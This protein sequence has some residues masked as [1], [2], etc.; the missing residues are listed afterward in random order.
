MTVPTFL[1]IGVQ[2]SGT[3]TLHYSLAR[4]PQIFMSRIKETN[5][6]L[7]DPHGVLPHW[8][9]AERS[10]PRTWEEYTELFAGAG[11]Q[12]RAIGESSPSYLYGPV[13]GRIKAR[14]P[15]VKLIVILRHPVDQARSILATWLGRTPSLVELGA[16]LDSAEPGPRGELPLALHGRFGEH[17]EPYYERFRDILVLRFAA[18]QRAP[19][20]VLATTQDFLG[21]E[22]VR[23]PRLHLN[24]SGRPRSSLIKHV[25]GAKRIARAVLPDPWL[26]RLIGAAHLLQS[27][28]TA[29]EPGIPADL[30]E[31]WTERYY[32][33]DIRRLEQLTGLDLS[34]WRQ[35]EAV[36]A[37][38]ELAE[39]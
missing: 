10:T 34:G 30:R 13:A 22:R 7:R 35:G 2:R 37:A 25:L 9:A 19:D 11:P 15:D 28:N 4:H 27:L 8:L 20:A 6:F 18:L 21:V 26:R 23:L 31:A 39:A 16:R 17:L 1:I 36:S 32:S 12:H 5:Y 24:A 33:D 14:L 29:G 3:T 38:M